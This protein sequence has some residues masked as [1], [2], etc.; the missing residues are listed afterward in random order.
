MP[1]LRGMYVKGTWQGP[2]R[3]ENQERKEKQ[4]KRKSEELK[5][6]K[7]KTKV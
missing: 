1:W 5:E 2:G 6:T 3:G 4:T 7:Y